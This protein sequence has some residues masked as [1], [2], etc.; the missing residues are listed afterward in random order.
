MESA[1]SGLIP[2][3]SVSTGIER[4]G[5]MPVIEA[6]VVLAFACVALLL[7][8]MIVLGLPPFQG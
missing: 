2:L 3:A 5:R 4:I 8:A 7:S 1:G 6:I